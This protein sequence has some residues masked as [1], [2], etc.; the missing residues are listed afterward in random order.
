MAVGNH[1]PIQKGRG[2][3]RA[4]G[5]DVVGVLRPQW[6]SRFPAAK[7]VVIQIPAEDGHVGVRV[8]L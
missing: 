2:V 8:A 4:T 6:I 3:H 7:V 5:H 1:K